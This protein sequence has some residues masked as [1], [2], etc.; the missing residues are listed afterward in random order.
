MPDFRARSKSCVLEDFVEKLRLL[1]ANH[2]DRPRLIRMII[3]LR[4]EIERRDDTASPVATD[5]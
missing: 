5:N 2:P 1:P 4:C 3:D